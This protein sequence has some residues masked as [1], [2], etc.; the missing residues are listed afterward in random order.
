VVVAGRNFEGLMEG[1]KLSEEEKCGVKGMMLGR[2]QWEMEV[3][4]YRQ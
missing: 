4:W 1:L 3:R 2:C